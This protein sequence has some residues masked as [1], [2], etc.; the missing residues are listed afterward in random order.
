MQQ[1]FALEYAIPECEH[2]V[3]TLLR[4]I[5]RIA[6]LPRFEMTWLRHFYV[7]ILWC[8]VWR[9]WL[10]DVVRCCGCWLELREDSEGMGMDRFQF[11]VR[12]E[13]C[14]A[15]VALCPVPLSS[16]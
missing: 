11:T 2:R 14:P 6:H 4:V 13:I 8:K 10:C 5:A 1:T 15:N 3:T 12:R 9:V 16:R 7:E